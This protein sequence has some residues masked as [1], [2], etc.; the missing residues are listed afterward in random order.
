[1]SQVAVV[2]SGCGF[3]DGAEITEAVS[4]LV[5]LD[6]A[7]LPYRCF[8][9]DRAQMHVVDHA[10]G[11]PV[12]ETR[13][14]LVESARIA[15]GKIEPLANLV[16]AQFDAIVFPGGFGAAKN[17]CNFV[18]KGV[19][20]TMY[21]DVR[22]ALMPFVASKK[23]VVA[24][25]ASPL[26]LGLAAKESGYR[27]ARITLGAGGEALSE[28]IGAWGQQ[29]VPTAVDAACVDTEHRFVSAAAYM[30][31]EATPKQIFASVSAAIAALGQFLR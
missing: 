30:Y 31:D 17:L 18:E 25:C 3:L 21:A 23:P 19:D 5:A 13:N 12:A 27:A 9:P 6:Q 7:G 2:L 14:I 15:R 11:V 8:A 28:A 26:L 4:T 16:P 29:H 24:I 20:A 10:K 1:M 22:T